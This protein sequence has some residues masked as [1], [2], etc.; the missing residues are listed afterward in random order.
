MPARSRPH[1]R[2]ECSSRDRPELAQPFR[3][4]SS[5]WVLF[6][7]TR[8]RNTMTKPSGTATI[9]SK[10]RSQRGN[11]IERS[12]LSFARSGPV[13]AAALSS[14]G[15]PGGVGFR[16]HRRAATG[17]RHGRGRAALAA[18]APAENL[19][20]SSAPRRERRA[21][22]R[23]EGMLGST[24]TE[25]HRRHLRALLTAFGLTHAHQRFEQRP[26]PPPSTDVPSPSRLR[27]QGRSPSLHHQRGVPFNTAMSR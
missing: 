17:D 26:S 1:Q 13:R 15:Q 6:I 2:D 25:Q 20:R 3:L 12:R 9:H 11:G 14:S 8:G 19:Q 10:N 5:I 16:R 18:A 23:V 22:H 27:R 21:A 7:R 24:R 4:T